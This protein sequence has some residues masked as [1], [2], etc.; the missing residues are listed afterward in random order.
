VVLK[1]FKI[2]LFL[3]FFWNV[4]PSVFGQG[5]PD[6]SVTMTVIEV[7]ATAI[8]HESKGFS[9]ISWSEEERIKL[10]AQNIA[11]LLSN[12]SGSYIKSY[13]SGS[14]ATSSVRGGSSGHTLVTWN[15]LPLNSP[16]LAQLDLS[17][18]PLFAAESVRFTPGSNTALWGSG[19]VGG[20]IDL[21]N[22]ADFS[23]KFFVKN[24]SGIGSFGRFLQQNKI[25]AGN[26]K[27][28]SITRLS[29]ERAENDFFYNA[30]KGIPD[31]Q[32]TNASFKQHFIMQ[33]LYWKINATHSF[34]LQYWGQN[35]N[36]NIPPTIVQTSSE[37]RQNDEIHRILLDLKGTLKN[38]VWNIKSGYFYEKLHYQDDRIL[39]KAGSQFSTFISELTTTWS[40][41]KKHII[42]TGVTYSNT[43][44]KADGYKNQV[45][46]E[47]KA[48]LF[49]SWKYSSKKFITQSSLRQES[50]DNKLLP[51][52]P[53]LTMEYFLRP[54]LIIRGKFNRNYRLPS[55]NDRFW[56]PGGNPEIKPESGWSQELGIDYRLRNKNLIFQATVTTFHRIINNWILWSQKPGEFFFSADNIASVRSYGIEPRIDFSYTIRKSVVG[57][58]AGY[59]Y[60]KAVNLFDVARPYMPA[61]SQLIYTPVHQT[62]VTISFSRQSFSFFYHHQLV[63]KTKGINEDVGAFHI[64]N[65]RLLY[66]LN[67]KNLNVDFF[68]YVNNIWDADYVVVERRPMPG[69]HFL[70]GFQISINK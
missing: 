16:M 38:A 51:F 47:N 3:S 56:I 18:L 40:Q 70:S 46:Q 52:I 54:Q 21:Q 53:S 17:L 35:S 32:Q 5:L 29:L 2:V 25:L 36:R 45:P 55:I 9:A 41:K 30:G 49:V 44:A 12:E 65:I 23:K 22:T 43:I 39:L 50:L 48:A 26:K 34:S 68:T 57:F 15:G 10:N 6:T 62:N 8:R 61:G 60:T 11:E 1:F 7:S 24:K 64:G 67:N 14:I 19:A 66:R 4:N 58:K 37:A 33:E 42:L 20:I 69:I 28:Q 13:G 63:G 27:F 31:K 59:D